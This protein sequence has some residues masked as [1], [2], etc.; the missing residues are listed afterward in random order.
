MNSVH[1]YDNNGDNAVQGV[2]TKCQ[3]FLF[4]GHAYI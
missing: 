4:N 2:N 1:I 3:Q